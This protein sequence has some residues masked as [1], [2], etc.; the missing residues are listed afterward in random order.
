MRRKVKKNKK[1]RNRKNLT[2]RLAGYSLTAG[3]VMASGGNAQAGIIYSGPMDQPFGTDNGDYD[4]T[5]EGSD[6]EVRF[7]GNNS[8]YWTGPDSWTEVRIKSFGTNR[9]ND[10]FKAFIESTI[11]WVGYTYKTIKKLSYSNMVGPNTNTPN[12][13]GGSFFRTCRSHDHLL[14]WRWTNTWGSWTSDG[15]SGYFGFSFELEGSG[16]TVYGWGLIERIDVENGRLLGW[17]YE[18]SGAEIHVGDTGAATPVI[19]VP[20]ALGLAA[21]GVAGVQAMRRRGKI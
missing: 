1:E 6:P 19:P 4:L 15:Q 8:V 3:L 21:L 5:M 7:W 11:P 9:L 16:D 17:A 10:N 18:D 13:Y 20:S 14:G 12:M 2:K